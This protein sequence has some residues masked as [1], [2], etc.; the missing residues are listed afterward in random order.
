L[1]YLLEVLLFL[2]PFAAFAAW[3]WL[4]PGREVAGP[5]VWL[6]L[7]GIALG[8]GGAIWY[9]LRV[10]LQ[11]GTVYVPATLG[12]DGTVVPGRAEPRR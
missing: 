3:R 12:P 6:L 4:N 8:A 5:V 9:G 10:S 7:L 2:A 11:P 1:P